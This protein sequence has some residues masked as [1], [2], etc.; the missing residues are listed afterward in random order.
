MT[1]RSTACVDGYLKLEK[2]EAEAL[3]WAWSRGIGCRTTSSAPSQ[4]RLRLDTWHVYSGETWHQLGH[5]KEAKIPSMWARPTQETPPYFDTKLGAR[6]KPLLV[7]WRRAI[8]DLFSER[9]PKRN[10]RY[11]KRP[12]SVQTGLD[13]RV[14]AQCRR[15]CSV[16][17]SMCYSWQYTP[18]SKHHKL[19]CCVR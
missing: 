2:L 4:E 1:R 12:L 18:I 7:R 15:P 5:K 6:D 19:R 11:L 13:G 17:Q 3:G 14:H 10:G 9:F 16:H 8:A